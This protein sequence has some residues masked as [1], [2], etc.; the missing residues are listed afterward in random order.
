MSAH[1]RLP[2]SRLRF[3]P[4]GGKSATQ[5]QDAGSVGGS[6]DDGRMN[7]TIASIDAV[8]LSVFGD[9]LAES[10]GVKRR[11]I[12]QVESDMRSF[13]EATA[14]TYLTDD[15]RTLLGAEREF[16][17]VGAACRALDASVLFTALVGFISPPH[18][19]SDLLLRRVQ[20][21]MVDSLV[22]YVAYDLLRDYDTRCIR[23]DFRRALFRARHVLK[24]ERAEQSLA[25]SMAKMAPDQREAME[26][27]LQQIDEVASR[28]ASRSG[29]PTT[30][31]AER[32]GDSRD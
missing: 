18:L 4:E 8:I 9:H 24:R 22:G 29:R 5:R 13:L 12:Q 11:R 7:E 21:D 27:A 19:P 30:N 16:A 2:T 14:D 17:P 3:A 15:E 6:A 23:M 28:W 25:R 20:L 10:T 1:A 31:E 32:S 26:H